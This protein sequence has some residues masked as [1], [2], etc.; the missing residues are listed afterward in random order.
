METADVIHFTA[1]VQSI[2]YAGQ[3]V[4]REC[5]NAETATD[6]NFAYCFD[7]ATGVLNALKPILVHRLGSVLTYS[8]TFCE[9]LTVAT[10]NWRRRLIHNPE[11]LSWICLFIRIHILPD[12]CCGVWFL[13]LFFAEIWQVCVLFQWR[14]VCERLATILFWIVYWVG[15]NLDVRVLHCNLITFTSWVKRDW[16]FTLLRIVYAHDQLKWV[17]SWSAVISDFKIPNT[18]PHLAWSLLPLSGIS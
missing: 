7:I 8:S 14:L 3:R 2:F 15:S 10:R 18:R 12:S 1:A 11:E 4:H 5:V 16:Y 13:W 17:V 9:W 6:T